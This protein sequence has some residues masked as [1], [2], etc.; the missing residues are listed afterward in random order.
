MADGYP[1]VGANPGAGGTPN[2][3]MRVGVA[4]AQGGEL[5]NVRRCLKPQKPDWAVPLAALVAMGTTIWQILKNAKTPG[6]VF[7][8]F[9]L[10]LG[11]GI[12]TIMRFLRTT[13]PNDHLKQAQEDVDSLIA[14]QAEEQAK[15]N[16]AL[17]RRIAEDVGRQEA[18]DQ[19]PT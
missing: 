8:P 4:P 14:W 15:V 18:K 16:R 13:E 5:K 2:F 6:E 12:V 11:A 7:I 10:A 3:E 19:S 1:L 17:V 9:G